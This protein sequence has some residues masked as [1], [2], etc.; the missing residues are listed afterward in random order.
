VSEGD[1]VE[2]VINKTCGIYSITNKI[3]GKCYVG[4][5]ID[6]ERKFKQHRNGHD[7]SSQYLKNAIAKYGFDNFDFVT[8]EECDPNDL[9]Y[10]EQFWVLELDTMVPNGYNLTSGGGQGIFVSNKTRRKMSESHSGENNH[11]YG[12]K[13]TDKIKKKLSEIKQGELNNRYGTKHT[14]ETKRKMSEAQRGEKHYGYGKPLSQETKDKLSI[15]LSGRVFSTEH[16]EKIARSL[17]GKE[18]SDSSKINQSRSQMNGKKIGCSNGITYLS[19]YEAAK[20]TNSIGVKIYRVCSGRCKTT[21]KLNFWYIYEQQ[22]GET[23][24]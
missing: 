6:I 16:R 14:E 20:D 18:R 5:S 17:T 19:I 1:I 24:D 10:K 9:N 2:K 22:Q 21:N 4:Q 11:F 3:N 15:A 13:H 8:I 23:N 7:S 12:L